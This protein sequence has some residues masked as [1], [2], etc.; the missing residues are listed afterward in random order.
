[1]TGLTDAQRVALKWLADRGGDGCFN[2]YGV[3]LAQGDEAETER[4][5]WNALRDAGLVRF[6]GGKQDGGKG[7]GRLAIIKQEKAA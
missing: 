1:M 4:K 6:Y 3:A 7:Y 2:K 5:T